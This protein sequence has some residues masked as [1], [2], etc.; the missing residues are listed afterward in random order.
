MLVLYFLLL[1]HET[2]DLTL[3]SHFQPS[4]NVDVILARHR[5]RRDL[6]KHPPLR[7]IFGW[8][9]KATSRR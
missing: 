6:A 9:V 4:P 3:L 5:A 2:A 1:I 8:A 7:N